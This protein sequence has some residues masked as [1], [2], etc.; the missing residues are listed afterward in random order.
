[1]E[2]VLEESGGEYWAGEAKGL[3]S[4]STQVQPLVGG[5][6]LRTILLARAPKLVG[7]G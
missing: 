1:M 2:V 5:Q 7:G 3:A 4:S 6:R